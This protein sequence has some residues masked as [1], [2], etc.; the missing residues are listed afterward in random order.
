M[1]SSCSGRFRLLSQR[2]VYCAMAW[3]ALSLLSSAPSNAQGV[4]KPSAEVPTAELVAQVRTAQGPARTELQLALIKRTDASS[5][6]REEA[7]DELIER[8]KDQDQPLVLGAA[9]SSKGKILGDRLEFA[10]AIEKL[11]LAESYG[12]R[13][14]ETDPGIYFK[15][16]CN[17]AVYR[18]ALGQRDEPTRML[19]EAIE[20]AKPYGDQLEVPFAYAMLGRLAEASGAIDRAFEYLQ[21]SF[22][23]AAKGNKARLAAQAGISML[24]LALAEKKTELAQEWL[25]RCEPWAEKSN[26]PFS[27]FIVELRR[28]DL[29]R[30]LGDPQAAA[31]AVQKLIEANPLDGNPQYMGMLYLSLAASRFAAKEY[32]E[33]MAASESGAELL[34]PVFRSWTLTQINRVE[35]LNA[36]GRFQE[37]LDSVEQL[38]DD[39]RLVTLHRIQLLELK[40]RVLASLDRHNDSLAALQACRA[41]EAK[42]ATDRAHEVSQFMQAAY[43]GQQREAELATAKAQQQAAEYQAALNQ[44]IALRERSSAANDRFVKNAAIIASLVALGVGLLLI[45]AR[46]NRQAAVTIAERERELN[47]QLQVQL[48]RQA[49]KLKEEI[50]TRQ[51]LELAMERKFRDEALGK[52]TGGVAHDFNNL[53]TVILHSIE[54][55]RNQNPQLKTDS[56]Q[57]IDAINGAAESGSGIVN[58]LMAY[59]RQQPLEPQPLVISSWLASTRTMFK[60]TL[61]KRIRYLEVDQSSSSTICIDAAQLTTAVINLLANSRD[62]IGTEAGSVELSVHCM[63]LDADSAAQ[64][65]HLPLGRYARFQVRDSGKGMSE[66]ELQHACEP[67]FTTKHPG[68]GTGL[69]L[70]TVVGFVK[71]SGGE[72]HL[73]SEIGSGT[74]VTFLL[75]LTDKSVASIAPVALTGEMQQPSQLLLVEDQLAVRTVLAAGLKSIGYEVTQA[76]HADEAMSIISRDGAPRILLSDVRMPGSMNGVQLRRWVLDRFPDVHVVLMSGYR[77]LDFE[78]DATGDIVY[79]QKPIKLQELHKA[80]SMRGPASR[81]AK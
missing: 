21:S 56:L 66:Q 8:Y 60:Q 25:S 52:L 19:R 2:L 57:L 69:G 32:T 4:T 74:T 10:A 6:V 44:E 41:E 31:E 14:A 16:K 3:V 15:A 49:V 26:D 11:E 62:A 34:K 76:E 5:A 50:A 22:E 73:A 72:L 65:R 70:S 33:A 20:F 67:F 81:Q 64:W 36:L 39:E 68:A 29:K 35:C 54:L 80:L 43:D 78:P 55:I 9:Y 23:S 63:Q 38:L 13:C 45:R 1:I 58:Q 61:G 48:E 12:R 77:D 30:A 71:Q 27:K 51:Q 37:S 7:T 42:R 24:E 59:T 79:L 75:P 47:E 46:S 28:H 17:Q 18:S 53:L 40:S